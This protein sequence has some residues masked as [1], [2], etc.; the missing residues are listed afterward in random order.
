MDTCLLYLTD[1]VRTGFEKALL[2][3]MLL[4]DLQKAFDTIDHFI[5]L[6][7]M[8]SL[9]FSNSTVASFSSY[10]TNR[11]FIGNIGKKYSSPG[12]LSYGVLQ[13]SIWGL[14]IFLLHVNDMPQAVNSKLLLYAHDTCFI[15]VGKDS[16]TIEEQLNRDFNSLYKW[17]IDNKPSIYF[18][19]EKIKSILFGTKG[20]L[21]NQTDL[22]IK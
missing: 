10:L 1:K 18:G 16:K 21:K 17:L 11:S 4:I 14:L 9:G 3:E 8:N 7:K 12:K 22:N 19:K 15:Y 20:H 2:T 13:G 5:L 6:D